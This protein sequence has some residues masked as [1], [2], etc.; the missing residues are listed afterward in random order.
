DRPQSRFCLLVVKP[1]LQLSKVS[2][3]IAEG[4]FDQQIPIR[5]QV[6]EL[7]TMAQSF[8][9]MAQRLQTSFEQVRAALQESEAKF[10]KIFQYSPDPMTITTL[11]EGRIIEVNDSFLDFYGFTL[12]ETVGRTTTELSFWHSD[13]QRSLFREQLRREG[14]VDNLEFSIKTAAGE[15]KT[16]LLSAEV[17]DLDGQACVL[18]IRRDISDRKLAERLQQERF[19]L[20]QRYLTELTEWQNRYEAAGQASGQILYEWDINAERITWGP[21]TKEILGYTIAEMPQ[22]LDGWMELLD[23][24][25]PEILRSEIENVIAQD[26]SYLAEYRIRRK[27]RTYIWIEDKCQ[28]FS[29]S[30]GELVRVIGFIADISDRKLAEAKLRQSETALLAAQRIAHVG[31]WEADLDNL[32][33][34]WSEG[35]FRIFGL[36]PNQPKPT[37]AEMLQ[38]FVHPDDLDRVQQADNRTLAEGAPYQIDH[39][40]IRPDGSIRYVEARGEVTLNDQGKVVRLFGTVLDITDRKQLE[41]ALQA[42]EAKLNGILNDAIASILSFRLFPDH[43]WQYDYFSAGCEAIFG[44]TPAELMA[45]HALWLSRVPPEDQQAIIFPAFD[46]LFTEQ[47][48]HKEYRFQHK[49]GSLHWIR[50]TAIAHR[51]A[52]YWRVTAVDTDITERKRLEMALQATQAKLSDIIDSAIASISSFHVFPDRT[53]KYDYVSSGCESVFGYSSQELMANPDLWTTGVLPEDYETVLV[54][55]YEKVLAERAATAEYRFQHKDG[56]LRWISVNLSSRW[57]AAANSWVVTTVATDITDRKQLNLELQQS[58]ERLREIT[59][60]IRDVFFVETA[61]TRQTLYISPAYEE[62]Y[63]YSRDRLYQQPQDWME[64]IHPDDREHVLATLE[65]QQLGRKTAK[66]Y[67]ILRPD[68]SIRWIFSRTFPICDES[69]QI[70]RHVG[71][72][73][74]VTEQKTVEETLL[75]QREMLRTFFDHVPVMLSFFSPNGQLIWVNQEFETV[76][77]W[78]VEQLREHDL[79]VELYPD[80][81][82]RRQV[83]N[84]IEQADRSWRDFKTRTRSGKVIDTTWADIKLSDGSNIGIGQDISDRKKTILAL[85]EAN[86]ELQHLAN[87]DGL[88]QIANRRGFDEHL[89]RE[90]NRLT[91][92]AAPLSLLLCDIDHFK[93]YNDT[94][95]H[96]AGDQCLRHIARA[97]AETLK[98]PADLVSRYGGEEF[99]VILPNTAAEGATQVAEFIQAKVQQLQIDHGRSPI[100]PY[101]T[102]SVGIATTIPVQQVLPDALVALA[103]EALYQ[104]KAQGRN[105]YRL[106]SL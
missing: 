48:A 50:S 19:T 14:T 87:L 49:D 17:I 90:W 22:T 68:G 25:H 60:N 91:R 28:F 92:E 104:A 83:T 3:A 80:P 105:A 51:E 33:S 38:Q 44:Y 1:I 59:D 71:I 73:E 102:V 45:D 103:D 47:I 65:K 93:L 84:T 55:L 96:I 11:A 61:D 56:N 29:D 20:Q 27:D 54:P 43:T 98:R 42:S 89:Q 75:K 79:M 101:I 62:V 36:D 23:P 78:S 12:E 76:L 74:D 66:E 95:G 37:R 18:A 26:D 58:E 24:N 70:L 100:V 31:S 57:D 94:Y 15:T 106:Y 10:T 81:E 67:R 46:K 52:D 21:N 64:C 97:I 2:R 85:E 16:I 5:F 32:T 69:G 99:A 41:L 7:E 8:N 9:Q 53:W 6:Y 13:E 40:I 88:T 34:S 63:G 82:Y 72:S 86:R 30:S 35:L 39:R 4:E 77:G